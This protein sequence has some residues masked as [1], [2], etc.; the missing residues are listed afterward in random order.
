MTAWLAWS[1]PRI[2]LKSKET[3][4]A[5]Q[6]QLQIETLLTCKSSTTTIAWF[7]LMAVDALCR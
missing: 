7:L 5:G 4:V 3:P 6:C 1:P 2:E